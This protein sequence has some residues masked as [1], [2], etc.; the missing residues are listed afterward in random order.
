MLFRFI[1]CFALFITI[2][3]IAKFKWSKKMSN[4]TYKMNCIKNRMP[5]ISNKFPG[6]I[7][8]FPFPDDS[9]WKDGDIPWEDEEYEPWEDGEVPWDEPND[10]KTSIKKFPTKKPTQ[11][12]VYSSYM[13]A[14]LVQ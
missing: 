3:S 7:I 12:P 5:I 10:N 11:P 8:E 9:E 4:Y 2:N 13:L 14:T 6:K 1:A